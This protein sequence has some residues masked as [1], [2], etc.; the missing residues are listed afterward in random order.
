MLIDVFQ[1]CFAMIFDQKRLSPRMMP[2]MLFI[3]PAMAIA[4]ITNF[5]HL[6]LYSRSSNNIIWNLFIFIYVPY[7]M[8]KSQPAKSGDY[9]KLPKKSIEFF[10]FLFFVFFFPPFFPACYSSSSWSWQIFREFHL[11]SIRGAST[12]ALAP[13]CACNGGFRL[14]ERKTRPPRVFLTVCVSR[15]NVAI[16]HRLLPSLLLLHDHTAAW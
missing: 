12:D 2:Y 9:N 13:T 14:M 5:R 11:F 6:I 3:D 1:V 10:C 4:W 7:N 15:E 16:S 8:E